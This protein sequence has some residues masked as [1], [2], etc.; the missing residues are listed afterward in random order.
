MPDCEPP[1]MPPMLPPDEVDI[2]ELAAG[3]V[4]EPLPILIPPMPD[5]AVEAEGAEG[6]LLLTVGTGVGRAVL[7]GEENFLKANCSN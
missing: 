4:V 6:A 7:D 2:L 3:V 5:E 1:A